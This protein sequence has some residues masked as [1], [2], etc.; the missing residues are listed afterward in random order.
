VWFG[1]YAGGQADAQTDTYIH[2]RAHY[3]TCNALTGEVTRRVG[4]S[5]SNELGE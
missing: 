4:L 1:R 5:D 3:N 2:R